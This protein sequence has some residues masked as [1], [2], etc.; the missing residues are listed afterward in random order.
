ME[1]PSS[2]KTTVLR[3]SVPDVL[4]ELVEEVLEE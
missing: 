4:E 1:T 2:V 3:Q